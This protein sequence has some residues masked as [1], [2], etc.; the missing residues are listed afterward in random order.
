MTPNYI[1]THA[2]C[3]LAAFDDNWRDV[4]QNC[5]KQGI[6]VINVGVDLESSRKALEIAEA[7]EKGVYAS[8]GLH[9][10][11][12]HNELP[13][14]AEGRFVGI[15]GPKEL[16]DINAYHKLARHPKVVA[17]G[18]VGLDWHHIP[19]LEEARAAAQ[20]QARSEAVSE[21][22]VAAHE[23]E[24]QEEVLLKFLELSKELRLP[25]I[26]HCREAYDELL[27]ILYDFDR[28]SK[29]F[30]CRGAIHSFTGNWEQAVR[31]LNADFLI[32]FP[33]LLPET[34]LSTG[35]L[36]KVPLNKIL[37]ESSCPYQSL[38]TT[39]NEPAAVIEVAKAIAKIKE[40]PLNDI[41]SVTS[42]SALN[43]FYNISK[44]QKISPMSTRKKQGGFLRR[45]K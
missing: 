19:F 13:G 16:F 42:Q 21:A 20:K 2:H 1:D 17:L 4:L 22:Y 36:A 37:L 30:N 28:E 38:T 10:A 33:A 26:L 3:N 25:I 35:A 41:A 18:E 27:R 44:E 9:P 12:I 23:K 8:V 6:W 43:L 24:L 11:N 29:G 34:H 5:V 31:F 45:R 15:E 14:G 7:F 39:R 40:T 32:S